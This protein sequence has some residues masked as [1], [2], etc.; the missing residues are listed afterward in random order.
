[1]ATPGLPESYARL[2]GLF[3]SLGSGVSV[4]RSEKGGGSLT[5]R[6]KDDSETEKFLDALE[7]FNR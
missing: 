1:M 4:K 2:K 6:F 7:K 3:E 5:V